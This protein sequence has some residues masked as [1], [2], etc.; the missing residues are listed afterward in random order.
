MLRMLFCGSILAAVLAH[1]SGYHVALFASPGP[2]PTSD[3]P[4]EAPS[5]LR[6]G[7][8]ID[9]I[10]K[11]ELSGDR[12]TFYPQGSQASLRVLENLALERI[13]RVLSETRDER[14]WVVSGT[15]TEY[16]GGNYILIHKAVQQARK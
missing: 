12:A 5:R 10:G 6:E 15:V 14:L 11:L 3:K 8:A 9:T 16:R 4:A 7:E 1:A 13:T 2:N